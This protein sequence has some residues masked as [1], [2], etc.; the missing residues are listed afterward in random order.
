MG[1]A[2][3]SALLAV[4]VVYSPRAGVVDEVQLALSAGATVLQALRASG[5][6]QRWPE[7]DFE[8]LPM[9]VWGKLRGP[10]D[11]LRD[12]DR[13]EICRALMADPM[14]ARRARQRKQRGL[15]TRAGG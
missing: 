1:P 10:A 8:A 14:E 7:V 3:G 15:P 4:T 9:G 2:E 12:R 6:P 11:P 5:L 13:V